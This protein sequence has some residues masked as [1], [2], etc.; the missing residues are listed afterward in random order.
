[1]SSWQLKIRRYH[2]TQ[3]YQC[4]ATLKGTSIG[5]KQYN[6]AIFSTWDKAL[7]ETRYFLRHKTFSNLKPGE[8]YKD[9]E[10]QK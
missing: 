2:D 1:M 3:K 9:I 8:I 6:S 5:D 10:G 7:A 4:V